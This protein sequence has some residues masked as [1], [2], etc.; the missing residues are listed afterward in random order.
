MTYKR[1]SP[2]PIAEGGTNASTMATTDGVVYFDGTSLVTTAVGTA[3]H[4]LTSNGAGVAPTFQ[5]AS[6]GGLSQITGDSGTATQSAGNIDIKAQPGA[7]ASVLFTGSTDKLLL[8]V[9]DTG[10]NTYIGDQCGDAPGLHATNV[11]VGDLVLSSVTSAY[12]NVCL[13]SQAGRHLNSA[14]GCTAVGAF[15]LR[16]ATSQSNN[17]VIGAQSMINATGSSDNCALGYNVLGAA[18]NSSQNVAIGIDT[19]AD[20]DGS[21][22]AIVGNVIIG[23]NCFRTPIGTNARDGGYNSIVGYNSF[24]SADVS[25]GNASLGYNAAASLVSGNFNL[26]LGAYAA[27]GTN[28][29]GSA[30]NGAESSNIIM[31]NVGVSGDNNTIRIGTSGSG[32]GQ[33]ST[34]YVAGIAGVT[35]ANSAAVLINT[36]TGQLGTVVSSQRYKDNIVPMGSESDFIHQLK[37]STFTFKCDSKKIKQYG[38]IAEQVEEVAPQLVSYNADGLPETVRYHELAS[39]LLNEIQKLRKEIDDL[40]SNI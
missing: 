38:L 37:P 29:V 9:T 35:V 25:K 12:D 18:S 34:C 28:A 15:S 11:G 31:Q 17:T 1:R 20:A 7:G 33:Q 40:K 24:E 6:S 4:V 16:T 27:D 30:W 36:T 14:S 2:Q 26:I 8:S 5:A 32:D 22:H 19:M 3:T 10:A 23:N 21:S 13:G 39:L